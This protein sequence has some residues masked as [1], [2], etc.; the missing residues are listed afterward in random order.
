MCMFLC[1]LIFAWPSGS[2]YVNLLDE[3]WAS[4]CLFFIL[5]LENMA[6][7][8]IYGARRCCPQPRIFC[9]VPTQPGSL[10]SFGLSCQVSNPRPMESPVR[11]EG[12]GRGLAPGE[13][14]R[15]ME[16]WGIVHMKS[17]GLLSLAFN[18]GCVGH[19]RHVIPCFPKCALWPSNIGI[20]W[21]L[22]RNADPQAPPKTFESVPAF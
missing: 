19:L 18:Q 2:Y 22:I 7:A 5:I 9:H 17:P 21:K 10:G 8:G 15:R 16:K 1:S 12:G 20:T 13:N 14:S 4:L 11:W 3:Y 6:M